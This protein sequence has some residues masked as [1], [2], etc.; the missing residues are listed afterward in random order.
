MIDEEGDV[1]KIFNDYFDIEDV[2]FIIV[3]IDKNYKWVGK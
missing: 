3:E 1:F 2:D